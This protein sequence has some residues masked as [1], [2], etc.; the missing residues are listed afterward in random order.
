[1]LENLRI[2]TWPKL[3]CSSLL[4]GA[5][6]MLAPASPMTDTWHW[7]LWGRQTRTLDLD[8]SA[9]WTGW[10]PLAVPFT[11]VYSAA[12][13]AAPDLWIWTTRSSAFM[14]VALAAALPVM[15]A[16]RS[17]LPAVGSRT[18]TFA[19]SATAALLASRMISFSFSNGAIEPMVGALLLAGVACVVQGRA[20]AA[21]GL[22]FIAGLGRPEALAA[23]AIVSIFF[24]K[25]HPETRAISV[26]GPALVLASWL[27]PDWLAAGQFGN[28]FQISR[29]F[30]LRPNMPAAFVD[31][32]AALRTALRMPTKVGILM[33]LSGICAAFT[34]WRRGRQH[35]GVIAACS[36]A[37][38]GMWVATSLNG[39]PP[40]PRYV[41]PALLPLAA[42]G[43][44]GVAAA[45]GWIET[46]ASGERRL[47]RSL[48]G[49]IQLTLASVLIA[50]LALPIPSQLQRI[51]RSAEQSRI[52]ADNL[53]AAITAAGGS[54]VILACGPI[55]RDSGQDAMLA[56]RLQTD[57]NS[58]SPS[59]G[60]SDPTYQRPF[61]YG[62][63]FRYSGTGQFGKSRT[64]AQI[65]PGAKVVARTGGWTI[66]QT[67]QRQAN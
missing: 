24:W 28:L 22:I 12:G 61:A 40:M 36:A 6:S 39:S 27:V 46:T 67:C 3:I 49:A 25:S 34:D 7:V 51:N 1:M 37:W 30:S 38:I 63:T 5:I 11:T 41:G 10:K 32:P 31:F 47:S 44:F 64:P 21:L 65:A 4:L 16:H 35:P 52:A 2:A 60:P 19:G 18:A 58:F 23:A 9:T 17:N 15:L 42:L 13:D 48:T 66:W 14:A 33:I 55:A 56:W 62:T 54:A 57:M 53:K 45:I 29:D 8:L 20:R 43:G 59:G 26:A 50:V